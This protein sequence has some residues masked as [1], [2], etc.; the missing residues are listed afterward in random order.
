MLEICLNPSI[1]SGTNQLSSFLIG[2]RYIQPS[3][4]T[5]FSNSRICA[6]HR[7]RALCI[8]TS[9]YSQFLSFFLRLDPCLCI[10][11]D[12]S[13]SLFIQRKNP[14]EIN[15]LLESFLGTRWNRE[16]SSSAECKWLC[17]LSRLAL[18]SASAP[19]YLYLSF[20][21]LEKK[22]YV[23][24]LYGKVPSIITLTGLSTRRNFLYDCDFF[25]SHS[26]N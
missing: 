16:R 5:G 9:L 21:V 17:I 23:P 6:C 2:L 18:S 8:H 7:T 25:L 26:K 1:I 10:I 14:T 11:L 15:K 3:N 19:L 12:N 22:I 20:G 24:S 13:S 4:I